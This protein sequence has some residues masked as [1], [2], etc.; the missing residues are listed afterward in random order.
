MVNDSECV[1]QHHRLLLESRENAHIFAFLQHYGAEAEALV[2]K[3]YYEHGLANGEKA[4]ARLRPVGRDVRT[5]VDIL[6]QWV[7]GGLPAEKSVTWVEATDS[8][9]VIRSVGCAHMAAW[10]DAGVPTDT[11]C[12]LYKAWVDGFVHAINPK[13]QHYK[14]SRVSAGD[15]YCEEVWE[16]PVAETG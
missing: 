13:I 9:V 16:L 14:N 5:A 15:S 7:I 12:R 2:K 11:A 6:I 10:K 1:L 3:T 4:L 8:R